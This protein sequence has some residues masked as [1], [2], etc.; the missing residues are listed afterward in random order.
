[1]Q[2]PE[3]QASVPANA[4][5]STVD[6]GCREGEYGGVRMKKR[7][8]GAEVWGR[9]LRVQDEQL[10]KCGQALSSH[11]GRNSASRRCWQLPGS[12]GGSC[13][14]RRQRLSS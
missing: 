4:Q 7:G 3:E 6:G 10:M 12:R 5:A 11:R 14:C 13:S 8:G 9:G 1:M 2:K